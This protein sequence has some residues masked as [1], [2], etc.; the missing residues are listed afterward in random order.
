MLPP[1]SPGLPLIQPTQIALP[2]HRHDPTDHKAVLRLHKCERQ[3]GNGRPQFQAV[4][5]GLWE[6]SLDPFDRT[7]EALAGEEGLHGEKVGREYG[8]ETELLQRETGRHGEDVGPVVEVV[9]EEHEPTKH[10]SSAGG[11]TGM[12]R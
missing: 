7:F 6:S 11:W 1:R 12:R 8:R 3:H 9:G 5:P 2:K 10:N 4:H